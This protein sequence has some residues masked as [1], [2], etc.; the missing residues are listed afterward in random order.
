MRSLPSTALSSAVARAAPPQAAPATSDITQ[1]FDSSRS[2]KTPTAKPTAT[3]TIDANPT[4]ASEGVAMSRSAPP[5]NPVRAPGPGPSANATATT[6]TT[7]R[8]GVA[9]GRPNRLSTVV[10]NTT[11]ASSSEAMTTN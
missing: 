9:P 4:M 1:I 8:S 10:C 3:S 6:V 2:M 11:A 7:T 5:R